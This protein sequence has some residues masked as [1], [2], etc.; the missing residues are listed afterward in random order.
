MP[1]SYVENKKPNMRHI[2]ALLDLSKD[3]NQWAN[4]GPVV[5]K[6]EEFI[7]TQ[8]KLGTSHRVIAC[9]SGTTALFAVGA[10]CN[11]Q[12]PHMSWAAS[13]LTFPCQQQGPFAKTYFTDVDNYGHLCFNKTVDFP[14]GLLVTN[15]FGGSTDPARYE[16]WQHRSIEDRVVIYDS[17]SS[18]GTTYRDVSIACYGTAHAF[19]FHHTK[20]MGFGEGGCLVVHEDWEPMIRDIINFGGDNESLRNCSFNGKMS[21]VSAA[22]ILDRLYNFAEI[23]ASY[24]E[25]Y[26]RILDI[27]TRTGLNSIPFLNGVSPVP[28]C[29]PILLNKPVSLTQLDNPYVILRKYYKPLVSRPVADSIYSKI[30]C[31]PCHADL[32]RLNDKEI[33]SVCNELYRLQS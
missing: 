18:Y 2:Y 19:S 23:K 16:R 6:L 17:A 5:K 24:T 25:Q 8:L 26:N 9:S 7:H 14:S 33:E 3:A 20:P 1:V 21:D 31:F 10:L 13:A 28:S 22:Y 32:N 12:Y 11:S 30:A 27:A 15:L 29:V 4:S